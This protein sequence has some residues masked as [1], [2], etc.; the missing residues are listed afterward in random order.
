MV[1]DL[2]VDF[3]FWGVG[4]LVVSWIL[5]AGMGCIV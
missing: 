3:G 2:G 5:A 4:G 1:D